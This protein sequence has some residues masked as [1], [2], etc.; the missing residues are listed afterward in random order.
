MSVDDHPSE[1]ISA[2]PLPERA[3]AIAAEISA[4]RDRGA[5][6]VVAQLGQS[7]DGRIATGTGDSRW[8]N[9]AAALDYL[10]LLRA[11]VDAVV[12]GAG[13]VVADD[14]RLSVRRVP[15]T[16]PARVVVDANARTSP[17]AKWRVDDGVQRIMVV[18]SA[19]A[20]TTELTQ[21]DD[22]VH[23][24]GI[25]SRDRLIRPDA[26]IAALRERG[27]QTLLIEGGAT[28]VSHWLDAGALDRLALLVGPVIIGSGKPGI[29][30]PPIVKLADAARP[31]MEPVPLADGDVLFDC[32]LNTH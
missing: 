11:S 17:Q 30:L 12:V 22:G 28:T 5:A 25:G 10:H 15:G 26:I 32:K 4:Y 27:L 9:G 2:A 20:N 7:I 6:H 31:A 18:R 3:I 16:N 29:S 13:T 24:L 19:S 8:I 21:H 23:V 14:P 1:P